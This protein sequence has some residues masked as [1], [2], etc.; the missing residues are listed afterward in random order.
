M[1]IELTNEQVLWA[2]SGVGGFIAMLARF[3]WGRLDSAIRE[4]REESAAYR[5]RLHQDIDALR[6]EL[7][8]CYQGFSQ[9][10]RSER[11]G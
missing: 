5:V 1:V 9:Q 2:A 6:V 7:R 11:H 3:F 8:E 10:A 4:S